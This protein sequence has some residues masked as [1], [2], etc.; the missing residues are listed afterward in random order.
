VR[1]GA[2]VLRLDDDNLHKIL[3]ATWCAWRFRPSIP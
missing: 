1:L 3:S 2:I